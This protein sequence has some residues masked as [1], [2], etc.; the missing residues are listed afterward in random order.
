MTDLNNDTSLFGR[1]PILFTIPNFISAG[2]GQ[3]LFNIVTRLDRQK[4][5]PYICVARRGGQLDREFEQLNISV[6]EAKFWVAARPLSSLMKRCYET[7]SFFKPF[8]FRA[9]HS[10][11]YLDDYTEPI[12]ARLAGA[13]A[14]SYTKKSMSWGSRAWWLRSL[15]A[16]HIVA[17]NFDMKRRFFNRFYLQ[18]KV[19]E[20]PHGVVLEDF[21]PRARPSLKLRERLS[22][23]NDDILIVCVA[24]FRPVKRHPDLFNALALVPKMHLVLAG[25]GTDEKYIESLKDL[26][27]E[28]GIENRVHFIG[29]VGDIAALHAE[30]DIF[31]LQSL[32]E[33]CPVALLEAMACG[34]A[35]IATDVAGAR[36]IIEDG[37]DGILVPPENPPALATAFT[38]LGES[39]SFRKKL[40]EKAR[41]KVEEKYVIE[42]E[43]RAYEDL[44]S[45]L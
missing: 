30:S 11:H 13:K 40:G 9:W 42:Q 43:V 34:K 12:I 31:V 19:H 22:L 36:D 45:R 27:K 25:S 5:S 29:H 23:S 7:A 2:S 3:V 14:W 18:K 24:H 15:L 21:S 41:R 6:L 35:C 20:I 1:I 37:R 26:V 10:F 17:D 38:K 33:G 16:K 8:R 32:S 44:L 4:F 28:L 39:S